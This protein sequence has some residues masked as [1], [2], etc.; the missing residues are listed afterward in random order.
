MELTIRAP[1]ETATGAEFTSNANQAVPQ[2]Y[3]EPDC[4]LN[5][6]L[7][8]AP[9]LARCSDNKTAGLVR[10]REYAIRYPYMQINRRDMVSW[11]IFDLDHVNSL[12]WDDAGLPAPNL[13]V[14]NRKNGHSH[15]FY[16][17]AP[18]C[19]SEKARDKP[20][21]YMKAI[22]TA[23]AVRLNADP[24]YH[25]GPVAKTP[26]HPW[27]ATTELHSHVYDLG[28]L[29]DTVDL[30][31]SPWSKGPQL[32]NLPHSR[33]CILFE[34]MRYF[35]YSIVNRERE[36][37]SFDSF[38][39]QLEAFAHNHNN[40]AR[41]G[42]TENLMLSSLRA[43]V[44]SV[45][46]W[47]WT[48]YVGNSKCCRGAMEL[49]KELPLSDRQRLAAERTHQVRKK[50][51]ESKIRAAC[52]GMQERGEQLSQAAIA[53]AAQVSRQTVANYAH[54]LEEVATPPAI[55]VL[56]DARQAK[57]SGAGRP[58][59]DVN[60]GA[61]QVS[62]RGKAAT[63]HESSSCGRGVSRGVLGVVTGDGP[64]ATASECEGDG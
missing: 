31:V 53:R 54:I 26:G 33:H 11:L 63:E 8:E 12:A 45:A 51:T 60:Y 49:D 37:G 1:G 57:A 52:R 36:R 44:R 28:E 32:D 40:F 25:S 19:T 10:P 61:H 64:D 15:L 6:I 34:Q 43:T 27:W 50:A 47:C 30:V 46:R 59:A 38:M 18:V 56:A 14:R 24:D 13:V 22:Y 23:F 2:R 58:S 16:A 48:K 42:F 39:R 17:I 62:A 55:A 4:S 29:A 35:A 9:Y 41:N 21:A 3:F 7:L 20:I 5:R